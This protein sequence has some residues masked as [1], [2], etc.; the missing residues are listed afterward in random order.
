VVEEP[1]SCRQITKPLKESQTPTPSGLNQVWH[2][3]T[4]RPLLTNR[5]SA[6]QAR[7]NYRQPGT[8]SS[9]QGDVAQRH[10]R[11]TGRHYRPATAG[12]WSDAPA[13]TSAALCD[14]AQAP[15]QRTAVLAPAMSQP[16]ARRYWLRRLVTGGECGVGMVCHRQQSVGKQSEDRYSE[17]RGPAPLTCGRLPPCPARRVRADRRDAV[18]WQGLSHLYQTPTR[19]PH[20]HQ[21]WAQA[22][23]QH[24][25]ALAAQ[26]AQLLQRR[27]RLERQR[28]RLRD[29]YQA[30]MISRSEVHSRR[31]KLSADRQQ[32]EPERE[33]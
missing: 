27:Q 28:Q 26:P 8:P 33:P 24:D 6:G 7:D 5:V 20:L 17:C 31:L 29:A 30:E 13:L 2:P 25:S 1:R 11:N 22:H 32:I 9:R 19:S 4:V 21:R 12:V 16:P 15:L 10:S 23:Q 14:K 3:A 18:V